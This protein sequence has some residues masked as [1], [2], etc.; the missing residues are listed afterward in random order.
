MNLIKKYFTL[1]LLV[2][3][4]I[5]AQTWQFGNSP[6]RQNLARLDMLSDSL[7]WAVSYDGL[8]LKYEV[9]E[10][11]IIDT[12]NSVS[13]YNFS[14]SDS[15]LISSNNIG[16]IYSIRVP[17]TE[18]G[19][20]AVNNIQQ[21]YFF[22]AK[23]NLETLKFEAE[24]LPIKI[25]ALDFWGDNRGFAVGDGG[26]YYLNNNKWVPLKLPISVDFKNIKIVSENKIFICGEDGVLLVGNEK[27]WKR[28]K[29][30]ID[31]QLRDIDFIS[32]NEGWVVGNNGVILHYKDGEINQE[33]GESVE[34]LWAV[35]M[36]SRDLGFAV[37]ENGVILRYNGDYWDLLE[38]ESDVDLHDIEVLNPNS[39]FIV[40]ARGIFLKLSNEKTQNSKA[41]QFLYTNQVHIG[42]EYLMDRI[43]DVYGISVADFNND[44]LPDVYMTCY[45]SLNH[46][47]IN[48]GEG[49]Y[50]DF[51]IESGTGGN[52]ETRVG[53]EKYEYGSIVSDFD[54]DGN[55]DILLAG[56]SKTTRYYK[57]NGNAQFTDYTPNTDL[58][59]NLN[60]IDGAVGDL[61][62]DGYPDFVFADENSGVS[63]FINNKYNR[64]SQVNIDSLKLPET[65]IRAVKI[66]D[67]NNDSNQDIIAVYQN[68]EP[69]FL[70]NDG[71]CNLI[72]S[73]EKMIE[74]DVPFFTNSIS[75][76]DFNNDGL[77]DFYLCSQDGTDALFIYNEEEKLFQNKSDTWNIKKGGRSYTAVPGDFNLDGFTDLFVTKF[78]AD[79]F[80][81]NTG[82]FN[83]REVAGDTIYAKSGYLSGFNTG[84]AVCD[85]DEN[86]SL[87]ILVGNSDYWSSLL[88]N[89]EEKDSFL[90][91]SLIGVQDTKEAL[92]A[93]IWIW[94]SGVE[95]SMDSLIS[96]KEVTPSNGL[97]SQNS[98]VNIFG[99][100]NTN[101]VD[102][103]IQF[104]NG[105][106]YTY[107]NILKGTTLRVAQS[108][109][110]VQQSYKISRAFLQVLH[111]PNMMWEIIKFILFS[112]LIYGSVRYIEYRYNWR[113]THTVLYVLTIVALYLILLVFVPS[114]GLFFN[115]LPFVIMF[116]VLVIFIAVNEPIRKANKVQKIN[117]TKVS[118]AGVQ[119]SRV[120]IIDEAF[121]IVKDALQIIYPFELLVFYTYH[122]NGN[123]FSLRA[124][125]GISFSEFPTKFTIKREE[126]TQLQK[127]ENLINISKNSF[128]EKDLL[129]L[130]K[131]AS[132]FS[133][134]RKNEVLGIV[135]LKLNNKE[136]SKEI[137]NLELIKYLFLHLSIALDNMRILKDLSDHEKIAAIG[138]FSSGIIHNLKNPIDGLRMIIEI[139]EQE[140]TKD[141]PKREYVEELYKGVL[142]LKSKL[143][144]SLDFV[145]YG[146]VKNE[147]VFINKLLLSIVE[148]NDILS[149]PLFDLN[150]SKSDNVVQGDI[151]Q[152]RFVFEN[153]IQNAIEASDLTKPI[154]IET[155]LV[156]RKNIRIDIIDSGEGISDENIDK[157]FDMFF[158]TKG[159][160]RGLGLTLT[161]K[162]IKSHNGFINVSSEK[163]K[164]T[165]FSI[166]L[167]IV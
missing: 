36:I 14:N 8:L 161:Q 7:G 70:L 96:F 121:N 128:F 25:R 35:D 101:T 31:V 119:L 60:I 118:E 108:S 142:S 12:L 124:G 39:S 33:I 147:S 59:S 84:A 72:N 95:H 157:I 85:I 68:T 10:W 158:S 87:D 156:G 48:Q 165:K 110:F 47:L 164:E 1:F 115:V 3:G 112:I 34:N 82:E 62:E 100:G 75:I 73:N 11:K 155:E 111:M 43:D 13:K 74:G 129:S 40:G 151:E 32:E 16:D 107:K 64:F 77:N 63:I 56:K 102:V 6:T 19:W 166:V 97:F 163:N 167:P 132:L 146:E 122:S 99:L 27:E 94:P 134:V 117:Q 126:V 18:T 141:D 45:K 105:D 2:T 38:I 5:S 120:Q 144:H 149:N 137:Q 53:K 55:V 139:L 143:I 113:P 159:K 71:S 135:V 49:V 20:I 153:L 21:H 24:I 125:S 106:I 148:N 57:N 78:G 103:K 131:G 46:L 162:I 15:S 133:L 92:G 80:Y 93:K 160:S 91:I 81:L 61:N 88:Q 150:L 79:L 109:F 22:I 152:F 44:L 69:I 104:L 51:V 54:R 52:I 9:N 145:N 50:K 76:S 114:E 83:F 127:S 41:H 23:F 98:N 42:S 136:Q 123:V 58:P 90:K 130:F 28:I 65:G 86:G 66:V 29:T 17:N 30:G 37:G 4:F 26:G 67:V 154:I 89:T 138:T 140:T 116:F